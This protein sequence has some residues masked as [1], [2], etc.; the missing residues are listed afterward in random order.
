MSKRIKLRESIYILEES[1]DTYHVIFTATRRIKRF[2]VDGLVKKVIEDLCDERD[3]ESFI[4]ALSETY[5]RTA[6]MTC[7]NSMERQGIVRSYGSEVNDR[8]SK[9]ILF[10]DELTDSWEETLVL[11]KRVEDS[12]VCV[13]GIG[14]IGTWMVNGLYQIGV[15]EIR[16]TDPDRVETSNLNRQLFFS[17]D[18]VGKFKVDVIKGKLPDANIE[19]FTKTVSEKEDLG[20]IVSGSDFLVNCADYP[21]VEY[22]TQIIDS[23]A[24]KYSV[25]YCAAGGYN[26]HLGMVGPIIVPGK[27]ASFNDFLEYQKRNDSLRG[28]K[29]IKDINQTGNLG[30][31]A[32][33]VANIQLM[34]IFKY[35]VG[36]G[37]LNLNRFAEVDFMNLSIEWRDFSKLDRNP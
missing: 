20:D 13:F 27:T 7:L 28:L 37:S 9:Q 21:S 35:L 17:S 10:L 36:K 32:G 18:D 8:Y 29:V 5:D 24:R 6:V 19:T 14:G 4:S 1:E 34:E 11:Q 23:Y 3:K 30:P 16:I 33:A 2:K 25:P 22:T 15:G 26:M 12:K 31:I